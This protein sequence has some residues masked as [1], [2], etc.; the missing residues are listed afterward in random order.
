MNRLPDDAFD[1]YVAMG[2]KRSYESVAAHSG[3]PR[4]RSRRARPA[5]DGRSAFGTGSLLETMT[6]PRPA[7]VLRRAIVADPPHLLATA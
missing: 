7:A 3:F 4:R 1:V 5:T 6:G 2:E